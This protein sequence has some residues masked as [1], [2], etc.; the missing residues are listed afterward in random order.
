MWLKHRQRT[1]R[2]KTLR[3]IRC[4]RLNSAIQKFLDFL[5]LSH[6]KIFF[7]RHHERLCVFQNNR[8][9]IDGARLEIIMVLPKSCWSSP[10]DWSSVFMDSPTSQVELWWLT[11]EIHETSWTLHVTFMDLA[12]AGT[13]VV[14]MKRLHEFPTCSAEKIYPETRC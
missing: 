9:A 6:R 4:S 7:C 3:E 11:T 5:Y 1:A 8:I 14:D 12:H 10:N 2:G 13:P